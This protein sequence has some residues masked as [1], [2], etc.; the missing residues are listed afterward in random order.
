MKGFLFSLG[1]WHSRELWNDQPPFHTFLLSLLFCIFGPS[2]YTA[3]LLQVAFATLL[4]CSLHKVLHKQ[5]GRIWAIAGI[6]L[7]VSSSPFIQLSSAAMIELPAMA[8]ALALASFL[9]WRQYAE[10]LKRRWLVLS[11]C[12]MGLE[13]WTP[14]FGPLAKLVFSRS[15]LCEKEQIDE[16]KT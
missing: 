2:A 3:R 4:V 12:A 11:G 7:L 16:T 14:K 6:L 9:G 5:T 1:Y 15:A 8:L 13:P 10:T